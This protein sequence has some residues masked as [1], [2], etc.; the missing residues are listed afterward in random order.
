M[1]KTF[2]VAANLFKPKQPHEI[3]HA[4]RPGGAEANRADGDGV[5]A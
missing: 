5:S 1:A 2:N 3:P 4:V